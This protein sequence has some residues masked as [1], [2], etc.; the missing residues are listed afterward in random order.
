MRI[1]GTNKIT[2]LQEWSRILHGS[3][4]QKNAPGDYYAPADGGKRSPSITEGITEYAAKKED[5]ENQKPLS[6]SELIPHC[7]ISGKSLKNAPGL[8]ILHQIFLHP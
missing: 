7:S 3:I 8:A 5:R 1:R 2:E 4:S 6:K